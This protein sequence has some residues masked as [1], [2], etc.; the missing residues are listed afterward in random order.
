MFPPKTVPPDT[1]NVEVL[2]VFVMA[3]PD[4]KTKEPIVKGP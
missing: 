3:E 2:P 4:A 1:I